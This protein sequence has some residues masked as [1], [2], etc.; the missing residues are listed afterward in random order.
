MLPK[1]REEEQIHRR[2]KREKEGTIAIEKISSFLPKADNTPGSVEILEF[3]SGDGF[4]IPY[5]KSLGRVT[6]SDISLCDKMKNMLD[7]DV[8]FVKCSILKTPF[9]QESFD[10]IYSCD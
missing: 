2:R 10:M 4:Q 3:G 5:L 8:K 6:A 9:G 7:K 1:T